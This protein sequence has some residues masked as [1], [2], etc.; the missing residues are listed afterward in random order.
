MAAG[1][2]ER[3]IVLSGMGGGFHQEINAGLF[4]GLAI[5]PKKG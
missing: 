3:S 4:P 2:R 1:R 5:S